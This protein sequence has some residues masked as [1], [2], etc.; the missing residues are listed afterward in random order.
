MDLERLTR[1]GSYR[2]IRRI[3]TAKRKSTGWLKKRPNRPVA[4]DRPVSRQREG[5][6]QN[7]DCNKDSLSTEKQKTEIKIKAEIIDIYT[8]LSLP[9]AWPL[10]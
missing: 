8:C 9:R 7:Q 1:N 2:K 3:F 10:V 4:A 6:K 5:K